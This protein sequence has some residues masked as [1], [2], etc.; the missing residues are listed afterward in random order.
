MARILLALLAALLL[1]L[2]AVLV[3]HKSVM[4]DIAPQQKAEK[5]ALEE[6]HDQWY[7][8]YSAVGNFK[9]LTPAEFE[10][11]HQEVVNPHNELITTYDNYQTQA[12][13][14]EY[15][16]MVVKYP[17]QTSFP[18]PEVMLERVMN[19][20]IKDHQGHLQDFFSWMLEGR[21][22]TLDFK[23]RHSN[24]LLLYRL[25]LNSSTLYIISTTTEA[26]HITLSQC[27]R[28]LDSVELK[29]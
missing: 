15:K 14:V 21:Y 18:Q 1:S 11:S 8:Y 29:K 10:H 17:G 26:P 24:A 22:H 19:E 20:I 28:F 27:Q 5:Q 7:P 25:I 3:L 6:K 9:V 16:I 2:S 13:D 12:S 23:L 4:K